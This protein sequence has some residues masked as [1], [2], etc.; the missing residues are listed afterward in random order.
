MGTIRRMSDDVATPQNTLYLIDGHAQ[1]FR[2]YHAIRGGMSSP[3][4]GE[5]THAVFGFAGMLFK[6]LTEYE[7]D[8]V[9]MAIDVPGKTFRDEM[10]SQYKAQREPPPDDFFSQEQRIFEMTKMFGI[11][12]VGVGGAEADDVI[13]TLTQRV[14][15]DEA[16]SRTDVRII[17]R[18]KDLEQLLGPRVTMLDIHKDETLDTDRLEAEKGI[19]PQQVVDVLA[20]MGDTADNIPGVDGIG[21]KTAAKLIS[22]YGSIERILSNLDKIKGKRHDNIE[23]ARDRLPLNQKLV[24]LKRDVDIDLDLETARARQID[25]PGLRQLFQTLGFRRFVRDLD[26]LVKTAVPVPAAAQ[27]FADDLFAAQ[28]TSQNDAGAEVSFASTNSGNYRAIT[29]QQQLEEL[30]AEL[31]GQT[32]ISVDTETTGLGRKAGL[33]GI[34]LAWQADSGVYVPMVSPTPSEHLDGQTVLSLL[35]PLLEDPQLGK[36]GHNLK[37]DALVLRHAGIHLRGIA[38]DTMI[39]SQLLGFASGSL[40]VVAQT[41]LDHAMI[42]ISALIGPKDDKQA[43]MDQIALEQITPYAAEDADV[44][45]RLY[46][47]LQPMLLENAMEHLSAVEMPMVEALAEMEHNGIRVN[48]DELLEQKQQ[49]NERIDELRNRIFEAAGETFDLNSPKQVGEVLFNNLGL[50][51]VKRVKTGPST[52]VEVLERLSNREDLPPEKTEVPRLIVEY[53]QY[54]KLVSTYLDNLRHS[55]DADDG[56]IHASYSQLGAATGRLSSGGPNLQNIPVRTDVGRQI[57]KAFIAGPGHVLIC[58]DYSQIE[59]RI[60]AHLSEDRALIEAFENDVDIHTAV[61]AQVFGVELDQV[62]GPQRDH[63]KVIN[64]GI[65]YGVT[66]YGLARRI[67]GLDVE[68]AKKLIKDYRAQFPGID[69]FL[70]QCVDHA[71]EHGYVQTILGRRRQI[72]QLNSGNAQ[73]RALGERLAINTVVQGSATGDLIKAAMVNLYR[74]IYDEGLAMRMLVQVHDELLIEAPADQAVAQAAIVR[75]VM[76]TAMPLRVPLKVEVGIGPDWLGAK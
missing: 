34:S 65:I 55:I 61:A 1:I 2:A 75:Q 22:E 38:F 60:L 21:P 63:A 44:A 47:K 57:R 6:L 5:A 25:A 56:R 18:D 76:E 28:E 69:K 33:C 41:M 51:V 19:R 27:A 9:V 74:R 71:L 35:K 26:Q 36:C 59:L 31:R 14:L 72:P 66:P 37:Y 64:F 39:A 17:S 73:T 3:V 43:T 15:D 46:H 53:R 8:Y 70:H 50:P 30:V 49:S 68:S 16:L 32:L 67:E 29:T 54:T 10:Y 23:A 12:V 48:P 13:A 11:P 4:T 62:T 7:P 20:L 45:L 40:D 42:P 58:A 52:D 24:E